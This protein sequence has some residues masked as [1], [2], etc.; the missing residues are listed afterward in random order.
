MHWSSVLRSVS[1]NFVMVCTRAGV[2]VCD[3][4]AHLKEVFVSTC[5]SRRCSG[6]NRHVMMSRL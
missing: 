3:V 4:F 2:I 1:R 5:G 6:A